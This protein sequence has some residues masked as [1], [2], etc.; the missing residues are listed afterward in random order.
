MPMSD[1]KPTPD[2]IERHRTI[3]QKQIDP[4]VFPSDE[5]PSPVDEIRFLEGPQEIKNDQ[6]ILE[7]VNDEFRKSFAVFN[8]I[9]PCV[10]FFGSART[11]PEDPLYEM[12][13]KTAELIAREGFAI[14]TGG[15]PGM[16]QA[17]NQGAHDAG[18]RS[19]GCTIELPNEEGANPYV[20]R[21]ASFK[22]FFVRKVVM[23]KY[24][25]GFVVLPGGYGTMDEMFE[26]ITLIQTGK[27]REFP[28][29]LMGCEYWSKLFDFLSTSM[30][31]FGMIDPDDNDL[32]FLTDDPKTACEHV[33]RIASRR[34][35]LQKG[36]P[37]ACRLDWEQSRG[38]S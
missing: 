12:G 17:A 26:I 28:V 18:G 19:V 33:T 7:T 22:H 25:Y 6:S 35:D 8:E 2:D 1:T 20:N 5:A 11:K 32:F 13:R 21:G 14:M 16:M 29:V 24:S 31:E 15:G 9:S 36:A 4:L 27:I 3:L 10:A 34:F 30:V 38:H 23:V 37:A